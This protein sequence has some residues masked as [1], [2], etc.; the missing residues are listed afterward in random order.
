MRIRQ[1]LYDL[2]REHFVEHFDLFIVGSTQTQFALN[3][4][5]LDLCLVF[6]SSSIGVINEDYVKNKT[7]TIQ[8]LSEI[9]NLVLKQKL[10]TRSE[11][12]GKAIVPIL[13][14]T[15]NCSF[16]IQVDLNINRVVT[17]YN[18]FLLTCYKYSKL[19]TFVI[20]LLTFVYNTGLLILESL[21]LLSR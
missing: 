3:S 2:F 10:C 4:S 5:D 6:Y 12:I 18:T 8:K 1:R 15:Y 21:L 16:N 7:K 14:F 19:L 20:T 17:I 11:L 13:K 9:R